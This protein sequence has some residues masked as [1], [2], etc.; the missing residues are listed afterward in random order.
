MRIKLVSLEDGTTACGF[1]KFAAYATQLNPD[2]TAHFVSTNRWASI[3]AAIR[4]TMGGKPDDITEAQVDEIAR[5]LTGADLVGYSSMTG[6]SELT[7]RVATRLRELEPGTYQVWG[8]IHP[9]IHPQD[10]ITAPVD[11]I[12]TGE[13]EFAFEQLLGH[14]E[15]GTDPRATR[16]FWFKDGDEVRRN[17]FLPLMS[18]EDME[19]L[20]FSLYG[21]PGEQ[22]YRPGQGFADMGVDDYLDN[23]GLSYTAIWSIGCPFHCTYCGNTAFIANDRTY[24]KIRHPSARYIVDEIKA[25]RDRFG[26]LS[27]VSFLDDSFMAIPYRQLEEFAEL[28]RAE[29]DIPFA[30]YG[31]IP[32]YVKRDKFDVLTWA[33]MNRIRMGVQ[34][35]SRRILDFY[36]RPSPPEKILAA[37]EVAASYAPRF[38]I[39]PTYDVIMDNPIE[40][41]QD[42]VDTL[43]LFYDMPRPY[44][45]LIYSLKVIPNTELARSM[46]EQGIDLEEID[47]SYLWIPPRAANLLLYVL[48]LWRPPR[49]L[50]QR[51][52][53]RV[54]ASHEP[55]PLY[56]R[57]GIALRTLFLAKRALLHLRVMDFSII[58]GRSGWLAWRLGLVG[59]WRRR[60]WKRPP[61]PAP[62]PRPSR[63]E[64]TLPLADAA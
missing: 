3:G 6:Y 1:R 43:Q 46:E 57:L 12:C 26:H 49:W 60:M 25:V 58:P 16:N 10:A 28:W 56:P 29:L 15:A 2:T 20:P 17:G 63:G 27:Q 40:T 50:W 62:K 8:G 47:S 7:R 5:G 33:G 38:H 41:R 4:G 52:L 14:L 24:K 59:L 34:S 13:G 37:G 54:R 48:A 31:V 53:A 55:Q 30:V 11:A 45:L 64:I 35:G 39:P 44:T 18:S 22:V 9:I 42:V 61:R 23:D 19:R 21:A 32:N 51:L 36:Q